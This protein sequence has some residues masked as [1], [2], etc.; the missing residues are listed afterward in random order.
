MLGTKTIIHGAQ[1]RIA[2]INVNGLSRDKWD[3]LS[4]DLGSKYDI[5]FIAETWYLQQDQR[6]QD[7]RTF[8]STT[9]AHPRVGMRQTGG[10]LCCALPQWRSV[11]SAVSSS[12]NHISISIAGHTLSA[13]YLQ[14]SLSD[15]QF[16]TILTSLPTLG[17]VIGD[18]NT[19]FGATFRDTTSGPAGRI[20]IL[21]TWAQTWSMR[22]II[23]SHGCARVDHVYS[24]GAADVEVVHAP[25]TTDHELLML[26]LPTVT[27]RPTALQGLRRYRLALLDRDEMSEMMTSAYDSI[28][29][30]TTSAIHEGCRRLPHLDVQGRQGM[31]DALDALV[32][33][34]V[35]HTAEVCLGSYSVTEARS[36]PDT[37]LERLMEAK[38]Q[39]SAIQLFKRSCRV[40]QRPLVVSDP[41]KTL[42]IEVEEHFKS[43]YTQPRKDLLLCKHEL[44]GMYGVGDWALV[45]FVSEQNIAKFINGYPAHKSCGIDGIHV[46][47]MKALS[48]GLLTEH[49][50][51]L[52]RLCCLTGLTPARWNT[53]LVFPI[54]KHKDAVTIAEC[55]P[56]AL[57]SMFRRA[58]ESCVLRYI[59]ESKTCATL[60]SF[61]TSQGGFVRGHSTLLHSVLSHDRHAWDHP[62]RLFIDLRQAYDRVPIGR[63]LCKMEERRCPIAVR[64]LILGLLGS[65]SVQVVANGCL[66]KKVPME[67]GILQGSLLSPFLFDVFI[68]DLA[69]ELNHCS[70]PMSPAALLFADDIQLLHPDPTSIQRLCDITAEWCTENGMQVGIS[71]CGVIG[72]VGPFVLGREVVPVVPRYKYLGFLHGT[73]GIDF[74][75]HMEQCL[76]KA[77]G[78]LSS[79]RLSGAHWPPWIKL[80]IF[81]SFVRPQLEYGAPLLHSWIR[82]S[83]DRFSTW[84]PVTAFYHAAVKWILPMAPNW[85]AALVTLAI[86][87]PAQR[88]EGLAASFVRHVNRMAPEHPGRLMLAHYRS[89]PPWPASVLL[90]RAFSIPLF[91]HVTAVS[92]KLDIGFSTALKGWHL[93]AIE[94]YSSL[95][96]LMTRACRKSTYGPDSCCFIEAEPLR[97][98]ALQWRLNSFSPKLNCLDRHRFLRSCVNRCLLDRLPLD[99]RHPDLP[100]DVTHYCVLDELLN[101]KDYDKFEVASASLFAALVRSP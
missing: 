27:P 64:S 99:L 4:E 58:F 33:E 49:L 97:T 23:P 73:G 52:F 44:D 77:S 11:M 19:R 36:G 89:R 45:E 63:L 30:L 100:H 65:G 70:A 20:S 46:R 34:S 5:L 41:L 94:T 26:S 51:G 83:A 80:A 91:D 47:I 67:R 7:P 74:P 16:Q 93:D 31:I 71:K 57:T 53:A 76:K 86:P 2:F 66:T 68:D 60:R 17:T 75:A 10:M 8:L 96:R 62:I 24:V 25:V 43:V 81:K 1:L 61:H 15:E 56:I 3:R 39:T 78:L 72:H 85:C 42:P 38:T 37:A 29:G 59:H 22:H 32:L 50:H 69:R 13:V 35:A 6:I 18:F 40:Q 88:A 84:D 14:P 90:P 28:C 87:K 92:K 55:R 21:G 12:P 82:S 9:N 54:P 48:G 79:C 101:D 98:R 95:A